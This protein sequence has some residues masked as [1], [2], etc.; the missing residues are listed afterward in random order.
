MRRMRYAERGSTLH[1]RRRH[2][3][4]CARAV[5]TARRTRTRRPGS[6]L[7]SV[8]RGTGMPCEL[9]TQIR[10]WRCPR[11]SAVRVAC[12]SH[13]R[14][15]I[16]NR[17]SYATP[18]RPH[19]QWWLDARSSRWV[20]GDDVSGRRS[21]ANEQFLGYSTKVR[22]PRTTVPCSLNEAFARMMC[23]GLQP[24]V[25]SQPRLSSGLISP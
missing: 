15:F 22:E 3:R 19:E 12:A 7:A 23:W 11:H 5:K 9:N 20:S 17:R 1:C 18:G 21:C 2:T 6:S 8:N 4:V 13:I 10:A 16:Q 14:V 24:F 25:V